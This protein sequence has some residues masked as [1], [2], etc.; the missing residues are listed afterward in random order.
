MM[1]RKNYIAFAKATARQV[2]E[3]RSYGSLNV[4]R[5]AKLA[6]INEIVGIAAD[7]FAADNPR[8]DRDRFMTA[9]FG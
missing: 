6:G 9:C 8:F 4:E 3:V 7:L 2:Q 1:T 5:H